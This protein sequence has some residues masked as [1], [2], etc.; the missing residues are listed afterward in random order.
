MLDIMKC[1]DEREQMPFNGGKDELVELLFCDE[2]DDCIFVTLQGYFDMRRNS[3]VIPDGY[4]PRC[5]FELG[6]IVADTVLPFAFYWFTKK[7]VDECRFSLLEKSMKKLVL[8]NRRSLDGFI[9]SDVYLKYLKECES[10]LSGELENANSNCGQFFSVA[11]SELVEGKLVPSCYSP[12]L[13]RMCKELEEA[14]T[15]RL[16]DVAEIMMPKRVV[17]GLEDDLLLR[18]RDVRL[19]VSFGNLEQGGATTVVLKRGDVVMCVN[20]DIRTVVFE[21]DDD[22]TVYAAENCFVMRPREVSAEYLCLYLS[23]DVAKAILLSLAKGVVFKHLSLDDLVGFPVVKPRMGDEYYRAEYDILSG[24]A[25]RKYVDLLALRSVEPNAIEV[26][27]DEDIAARINVYNEERLRSFLSSDIEELN[28]CFANGAYKAAI[29]LAGSI[30]EAVLIDWFSEI[31]CVNYF[32]EDY[33]VRDRRTGRE[34]RASL[35]D[36]INEI[37]CIEKPRWRKEASLAHEIRKK[38]NLVHAK[39][40]VL[41]SGINEKTARMVIEYLEQVLKARGVHSVRV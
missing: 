24:R 37:E 14:D 1:I 11:V 28:T 35:S 15:V 16:V 19:P 12:E 32:E 7:R 33:Y 18:G 31:K 40:C 20:N 21:S 41:E 30:L 38:R 27:L 3:K 26:I 8:R 13:R 17:G 10:Y 36:Y 2:P 39:L 22:R 25:S 9:R 4:T 34:R 5:V 29:I 6:A 23:S